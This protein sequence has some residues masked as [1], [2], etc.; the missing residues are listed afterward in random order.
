VEPGGEIGL[1][2]YGK[3]NEDCTSAKPPPFVSIKQPAHGTVLL[4][5][6]KLPGSDFRKRCTAGTLDGVR[7]WYIADPGFQGF[8]EFEFRIGNDSRSRYVLYSITVATGA[9]RSKVRP[10]CTQRFS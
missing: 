6:E 9:A 7:V 4:C 5:P 2:S 10:T 3:W 1:Y 8:D